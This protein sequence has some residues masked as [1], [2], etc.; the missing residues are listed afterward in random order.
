MKMQKEKA[1]KKLSDEQLS[2]H[3]A[4]LKAVKAE[5]PLRIRWLLLNRCADNHIESIKA[6]GS[7]SFSISD[8]PFFT[9]QP[10]VRPLPTLVQMQCAQ[11][12]HS[13]SS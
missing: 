1:F 8:V 9:N 10:W 12:V 4:I 2:S 11:S 6:G 13:R 5:W 3:I 7:V